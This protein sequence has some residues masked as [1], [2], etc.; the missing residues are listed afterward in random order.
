MAKTANDIAAIES[1]V[2]ALTTSSA[3]DPPPVSTDM[4]GDASA[5]RR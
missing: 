5:T 4:P 2:R 1:H 3:L